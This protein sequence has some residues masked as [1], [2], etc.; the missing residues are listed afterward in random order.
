[1]H[2]PQLPLYASKEQVIVRYIYF[3]VTELDAVGVEQTRN[4]ILQLLVFDV[5]EQV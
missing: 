4:E 3:Y 5:I 2:Q 1:M